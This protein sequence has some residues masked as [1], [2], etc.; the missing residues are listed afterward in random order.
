[1]VADGK[2][3]GSGK[4]LLPNR[5]NLY[6]TRRKVPLRA[7]HYG[8]G[9][10]IIARDNYLYPIKHGHTDQRLGNGL[11]RIRTKGRVPLRRPDR[12]VGR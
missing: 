12:R 11:L 10:D 2:K 3:N 5:W 8:L 4:V 9:R 7:Q 1:M 6:G